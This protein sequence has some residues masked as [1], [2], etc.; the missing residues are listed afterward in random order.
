MESILDTVKAQ[1]EELLYNNAADFEIAKVLKKD[2]KI[3]H[4]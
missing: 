4:T 2:I 1:I 3:Y